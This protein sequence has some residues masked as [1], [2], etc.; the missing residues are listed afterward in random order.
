MPPRSNKD[1]R[2]DNKL[3]S[4]NCTL[5]FDIQRLCDEGYKYFERHFSLISG[6]FEKFESYDR[7]FRSIINSWLRTLKIDVIVSYVLELYSFSLSLSLL[8]DRKR[9]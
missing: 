2:V 4:D 7:R 1:N 8:R 5:I 3:F 9:N 6:I